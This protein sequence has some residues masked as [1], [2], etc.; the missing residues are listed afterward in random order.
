MDF[1]SQTKYTVVGEA[2][3][4]RAGESVRSQRDNLRWL[5]AYT[6]MK[7]P[8]YTYRSVRIGVQMIRPS[9]V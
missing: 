6:Y 5:P 7:K 2:H 4:A 1:P 9:R 8:D 3:G